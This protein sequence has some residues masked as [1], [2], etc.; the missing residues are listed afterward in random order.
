MKFSVN[1]L[2]PG[3]MGFIFLR[4]DLSPLILFQIFIK[5]EYFKKLY[6]D[7]K[8]YKNNYF[9]F[10]KEAENETIFI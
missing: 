2:S 10:K 5:S 6:I 8:I 9:Y 4:S 7:M 1:H 3:D